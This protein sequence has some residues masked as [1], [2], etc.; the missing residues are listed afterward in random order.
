MVDRS[1][2]PEGLAEVVHACV[3]AGVDRVQLRDRTLE[4]AAWLAH[5]EQIGEAARRARP[6]VE[7][8]VNRRVD[9]AL[10]VG[11]DGVHLGFDAMAIADTRALVGPKTLIGASTHD[12]GAVRAALEAG[13]DYVHLAPIFAPLSKPATRAPLGLATLG[14]ACRTGAR[15]IAQ[16][17]VEPMNARAVVEAGAA[18]VAVTGALLCAPDPG[19][20]TRCL[21]E[22]L[23]AA[24][25]P[26]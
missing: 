15:V 16:G 22:A 24:R 21:R 17:G 7:I 3:R 8:V 19:E 26:A 14:E 6:D 23:D 5:A 25:P 2:R 1:L 20:A 9:V 11:A 13:A 18:G 4:G 12:V 10:A